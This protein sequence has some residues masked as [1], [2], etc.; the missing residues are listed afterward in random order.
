[1]YAKPNAVSYV[2]TKKT[3]YFYVSN[4]LLNDAITMNSKFQ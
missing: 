3:F 1:M 2:A 4:T